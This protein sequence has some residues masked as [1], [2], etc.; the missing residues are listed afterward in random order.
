MTGSCHCQL[1]CVCNARK[2]TWIMS[3]PPSNVQSFTPDDDNRSKHNKNT[4]VDNSPLYFSD[5]YLGVCFYLF[6]F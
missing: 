1:F 5:N 2:L 3:F 6:L 4:R